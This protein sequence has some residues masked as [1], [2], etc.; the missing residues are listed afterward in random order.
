M[1]CHQCV[2]G[3]AINRH[4]GSHI[5]ATRR[6][7]TR[8][9]RALFAAFFVLAE[10]APGLGEAAAA[11]TYPERPVRIVVPLAAGGA[12]DTVA[13]IVAL[14]LADALG[15]PI[16]V[17]NR[18]GGA[19][20]IGTEIVAQSRP[21]GHT[22]LVTNSSAMANVSLYRSLPFDFQRD[23]APVTQIAAT[24]LV[25]CVHPSL[26]VR[27]VKELV[28]LARARPGQLTYGSGGIG[29]PTYIAGALFESLANVKLVHVPHKG[30]GQAIIEVL[31]GQ[32]TM[33]FSGTVTAAPHIKSGKLRP[34]GLTAARPM[35]V[36]PGVPSVA[37]AGLPGYE[38]TGWFSLFAPG[39]TPRDIIVRLH[40]ETIKVLEQPDVRSK[41]SGLGLEVLG[42]TPAQLAALVTREIDI[43]GRIIRA[44]N[45]R[46]D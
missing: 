13:R 30:G 2:D 9:L 45:I 32:V 26:P 39:A 6:G 4:S 41:L 24:S 23:F 22:L 15:K 12:N 37:E 11:G 16:V 19:T 28:S 31:S 34:L 21:D 5:G 25:L 8:H 18:P 40:A 35:A 14:K 33:S 1:G 46:L 3:P 29:G 7:G 10:L 27:T 43:Y 38:V 36:L 20:N 17:D 44:N 42:G